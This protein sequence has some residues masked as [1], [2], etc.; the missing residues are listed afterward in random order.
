MNEANIK[1]SIYYHGMGFTIDMCMDYSPHTSTKLPLTYR[2]ISDIKDIR[3]SRQ[4]S[5]DNRNE[6][7][8]IIHYISIIFEVLSIYYNSTKVTLIWYIDQR[9]TPT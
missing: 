4:D 2:D 9:D 8:I 3:L 7:S 5:T 6:T 1:A